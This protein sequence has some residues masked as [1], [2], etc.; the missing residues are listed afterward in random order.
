MI[1]ENTAI[2]FENFT[3]LNLESYINVIILAI[4]DILGSMIYFT[5]EFWP[6]LIGYGALCIVIFLAKLGFHK[7][8]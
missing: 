5:T 1:N 6:Y 3:G 4:K 7:A 8:L 2:L